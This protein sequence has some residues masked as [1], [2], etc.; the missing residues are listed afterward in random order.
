M[1]IFGSLVGLILVAPG[2]VLLTF[3]YFRYKKWKEEKARD[4]LIPELSS[5]KQDEE[6]LFHWTLPADDWK[7][8]VDFDAREQLK[9]SL[10]AFIIVGV[11]CAVIWFS[12][13]N[14]TMAGTISALLVTYIAI[15]AIVGY[16]KKMKLYA[17]KPEVIFKPSGLILNDQVILYRDEIR[18]PKEVRILDHLK[19][20]I[21]EIK[22]EKYSI[23]RYSTG[24]REPFLSIRVPIPVDK[25]EEAEIMR[26]RIL[27]KKREI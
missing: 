12:L 27:E 8:F 26:A 15:A 4:V 23:T 22:T 14:K 20:P 16:Y 17:A 10:F 2:A 1:I 6:V 19:P 3:G 25:M 9:T 18:W 11:V 21:L 7:K 13:P 5:V 24:R